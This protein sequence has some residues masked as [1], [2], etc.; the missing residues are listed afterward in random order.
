MIIFQLSKVLSILNH[1]L[2]LHSL[3]TPCW[4][5]ESVSHTGGAAM[6]KPLSEFPSNCYYKN[7]MKTRRYL[8]HL[9]LNLSEYF[10]ILFY[11]EAFLSDEVFT[12]LYFAFC[13]IHFRNTF[14]VNWKEPWFQAL[15][16]WGLGHFSGWVKVTHR[17]LQLCLP[18]TLTP[19]CSQGNEVRS[20]G[21]YITLLVGL[22]RHPLLPPMVPFKMS[23]SLRDI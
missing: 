16:L 15:N 6:S 9:V 10:R 8:V 2:R 1:T 19:T 14:H 5:S 13:P 7:I 18:S 17:S 12:V 3:F 21:G 22:L 4:S 23:S 11:I 20:T